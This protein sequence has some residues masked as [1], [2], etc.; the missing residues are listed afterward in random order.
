MTFGQLSKFTSAMYKSLTP[1]EKARW[2]EAAQQDKA[3]YETEMAGYV[4]PPAS[5]RRASSSTAASPRGR[6]SAPRWYP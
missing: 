4:P 1:E 2:E 5:T 6:A 3:R